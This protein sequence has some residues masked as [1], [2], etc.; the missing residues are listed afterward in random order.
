[1]A[2]VIGTDRRYPH[3]PVLALTVNFA[4]RGRAGSDAAVS[5]GSALQWQG[6]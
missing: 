3:A 6:F 2:N 1:L 5:A 4:W